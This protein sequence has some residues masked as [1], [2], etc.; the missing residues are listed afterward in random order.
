MKW[1][2]NRTLTERFW[3]LVDRRADDECW[4]WLGGHYKNGYGHIYVGTGRKNRRTVPAH[5]IA[6]WIGFGE[7]LEAPI[8]TRHTCDNRDCVN[9]LNHLI[10]GSKKDNMQDAVKRGRM[11]HGKNHYNFK[12]GKYSKYTEAA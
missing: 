6:Y 4:P 8:V 11:P 7:W 3:D 1:K 2:Q 12:D 10:K 5:K 9:F